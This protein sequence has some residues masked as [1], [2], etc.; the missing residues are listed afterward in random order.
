[1]K[2]LSRINHQFVDTIPT[3]LEAG[4]LYISMAYS[5]AVHKCCCGCGSE[6]VTPLSP[7]DWKLVFDGD[8]ISLDPSIGNWSLDCKSHYWI[9]ESLI[10]WAPRWS[11]EEIERG[12]AR[13]RLAKSQYFE[14]RQKLREAQAAD[15]IPDDPLSNGK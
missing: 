13:D 15:S 9:E 12:R 3:E 5:T 11:K 7:T 4:T 10:K 1:M 6:V 8:T 14:N 2:A